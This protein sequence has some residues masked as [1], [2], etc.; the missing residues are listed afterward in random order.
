[1]NRNFFFLRIK[2]LE[3]IIIRHNEDSNLLGETT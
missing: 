1:M 2:T 3:K